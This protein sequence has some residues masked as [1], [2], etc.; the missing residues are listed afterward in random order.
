[1]NT[2]DAV[3]AY[4]GRSCASCARWHERATLAALATD[5]AELMD[6]HGFPRQLSGGTSGFDYGEFREGLTA[7]S[8]PHG[9]LVCHLGCRNG[10]GDPSCAIRAC[11]REHGIDLCFDCNEFPCKRVSGNEFIRDAAAEYHELGR[12]AWLRREMQRA[13]DGYE[14]RT[15]KYYRICVRNYPP[16]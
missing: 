14:Q 6:A 9:P 16:G 11:C 5:L 15:G 10:D 1:M 12:D 3:I 2:P 7:L 8:N 4:C 13:A